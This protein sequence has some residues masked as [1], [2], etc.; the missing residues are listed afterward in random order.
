[1]TTCEARL[2]KDRCWA[3]LILEQ[4]GLCL[5]R[6]IAFVHRGTVQEAHIV[7]HRERV[8]ASEAMMDEIHD[9]KGTACL[10]RE[11]QTRHDFRKV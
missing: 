7:T 9:S 11:Q 8:P 5:I 2:A 3:I 1:M 10:D 4:Q 6:R